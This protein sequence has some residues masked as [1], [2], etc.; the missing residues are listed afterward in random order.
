MMRKISKWLKLGLLLI[1]TLSILPFSYACSGGTAGG[2]ILSNIQGEVL[3]KKAGNAD[4][5][6]VEVKMV[7]DQGDMI[8]SG[9][10]ADAIITFFDGSTIELKSGTQ[11]E[12]SELVKGKTTRIKLKQEIGET[13]SKVKK[14]VDP[15]SMYEIETPAAIA[16]VRGSS[17]LVR[18]VSDGT[19]TVQNISGQI[20]VTAQG[21]EVSIPV[22]SASTVQMGQPP[23]PPLPV[24]PAISESTDDL[25]DYKGNH[26]IG[27][28]YQDILG[29]SLVKDGIMW[30][31][32]INLNG[33]IPTSVGANI[34]M[35]W[36][37]MVDSDNNSAT[38]W[39]TGVLF[40][41]I[42]A[43]YYINF[44]V[45]GDSTSAGGFLTADTAGTHYTDVQYKVMG[46]TIELRFPSKDIGNVSNFSYLILSRKYDD[47]GQP[48]VLLGADRVPN[49]GHLIFEE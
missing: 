47:S 29:A 46:K 17:M 18:V 2:T 38:G 7:L 49:Q 12:I 4:W 21:V 24:A 27:E 14:L 1:L 34:F 16:G 3:V 19:T 44:Y 36:D 42:G 8:K 33:D 48:S 13:I 9:T 37:L 25:I 28:G 45:S 10:T 30:V 32:T 39:H 23:S 26:V 40:E 31:L 41:D 35:E 11:V 15:A 22:G 20:S 5:V 6:K 43:D